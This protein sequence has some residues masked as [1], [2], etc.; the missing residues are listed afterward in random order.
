MKQFYILLIS[1][2]AVTFTASAQQKALRE[3]TTAEMTAKTAGAGVYVSPRRSTSSGGVTTVDPLAMNYFTNNGLSDISILNRLNAFWTQ[4]RATMSTNGFASLQRQF[5]FAPQYN[6]TNHMDLL[7]NTNAITWVNENYGAW[8]IAC[9]Q[10]NYARY[11]VV[12]SS[13]WTRI[14]FKRNLNP[15]V[16]PAGGGNLAFSMYNQFGLENTNGDSFNFTY[17][18]YFRSTLAINYQGA[19]PYASNLNNCNAMLFSY[20]AG[21]PIGLR[22]LS[23]DVEAI[24][25]LG[26]TNITGWVDGVNPIILQQSGS[27]NLAVNAGLTYRVPTNTSPVQICTIGGSTNWLNN[28]AWQAVSGSGSIMTNAFVDVFSDAFFSSALS[29]ADIKAYYAAVHQLLISRKS[30]W[31]FGTSMIGEGNNCVVFQVSAPLTNCI[32]SR[33]IMLNPQDLVKDYARGGSATKDFATIDPF[34]LTSL[35]SDLQQGSTLFN[36]QPRND[37]ICITNF[38]TMAQINATNTAVAQSMIPWLKTGAKWKAIDSI[39]WPTNA[40]GWSGNWLNARTNLYLATLNMHTNALVMQWCSGFIPLQAYSVGAQYQTTNSGY[41]FWYDA[42][43][44]Q[45][46]SHVQGS[47]SPTFF[48]KEGQLIFGGQWPDSIPQATD[49]SG[50]AHT[51]P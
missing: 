20:A 14:I 2:F 44:G 28:P 29:Q 18:P 22:E 26:G 1:A 30:W 25:S 45:S 46:S 15:D 13:N 51:T 49:A 10:T 12:S 11:S 6:P 24:V 39:F 23:S 16:A 31:F 32:I 27:S 38:Y 33:A 41:F 47:N 4:L 36:D 7:G 42:G 21:S 5:C 48:D 3:A 8:G 40:L 9:Y 17:C 50:S 35:P 19:Y 37:N 34:L 43:G